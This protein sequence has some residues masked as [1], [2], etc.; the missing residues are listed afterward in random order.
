M[1][2]VCLRRLDVVQLR[3]RP[4]NCGV[5]TRTQRNHCSPNARSAP[6]PR[7]RLLRCD[8]DC[9]YT[10]PG[11]VSSLSFVLCTAPSPKPLTLRPPAVLPC[12][13]P[14]PVGRAL[15]RDPPL[16]PLR[17]RLA[18]RDLADRRMHRRGRLDRRALLGEGEE[19]LVEG[20]AEKEN[21]GP[22]GVLSLV[23]RRGYDAVDL[24][25]LL[26]SEG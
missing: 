10:R 14:C 24:R 6:L 12:L 17:V 1:R 19:L 7:V 23:S 25:V 8:R 18:G 15:P 21:E 16:E 4:K 22:S 20:G 9:L 26:I 11:T 5:C 2:L 3:S 13:R